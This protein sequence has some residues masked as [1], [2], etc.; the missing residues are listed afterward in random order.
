MR[1]TAKTNRLLANLFRRRRLES[2]LDAELSAYLDEMAERKMQDG[3]SPAEAR[4]QAVLEAGGLDQVKE[5][6][7]GA[8][9]GNGIETTIRDVRY[10]TRALR[11]SPGFTAVVILTLALG[12]GANLTMFSVMRAVLWRRARTHRYGTGGCAQRGQRGRGSRRT[13]RSEGAQ[14][15][16]RKPLHD[17]RGGCKPGLR[18]RNGTSGCGQRV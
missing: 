5:E 7:R 18:G 4:R 14:P 6:V 3:M 15:A 13:A 9:L 2:D 1:L 17:Q 8:W 11:R 12:I 10:A 16:A